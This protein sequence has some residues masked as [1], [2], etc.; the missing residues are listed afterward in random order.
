MSQDPSNISP[1]SSSHVNT[2]LSSAPPVYLR[3][4]QI[5]HIPE[6]IAPASPGISAKFLKYL[7][8][9]FVVAALLWGGLCYF[10]NNAKTDL[11]VDGVALTNGELN[12][13]GR[14][15]KEFASRSNDLPGE[16]KSKNF[17]SKFCKKLQSLACQID[18]IESDFEMHMKVFSIEDVFTQKLEYKEG[19]QKA[20][21]ILREYVV[22]VSK[23]CDSE[24]GILDQLIAIVN[25][26]AKAPPD[27]FHRKRQ[28]LSAF[29]LDTQKTLRLS[30]EV[31]DFVDAHPPFNTA[32]GTTSFVSGADAKKYQEL[33]DVLNAHMNSIF[34]KIDLE[35]RKAY[36][37]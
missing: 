25:G 13:G 36:G 21:E 35:E 30:S 29:K 15:F 20:R 1:I 2:P 22:Q 8:G 26:V 9:L 16:I 37:K 27:S 10:Y 7:F 28:V 24:I 3:P 6:P 19:R 4:P 17:K 33:V 23:Y 32:V 11:V 14:E 34:L 31:L 18:V 5:G 12:E